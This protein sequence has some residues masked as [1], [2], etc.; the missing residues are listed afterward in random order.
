M[1]TSNL[2]DDE[3][4]IV[5]IFLDDITKV[6][7]LSATLGTVL[8]LELQ[9]KAKNKPVELY[10]GN[11]LEKAYNLVYSHSLTENFMLMRL[12]NLS[13]NLNFYFVDVHGLD[14]SNVL[15]YITNNNIQH[16]INSLDLSGT[17]CFAGAIDQIADLH[18][19][20]FE[21]IIALNLEGSGGTLPYCFQILLNI[22]EVRLEDYDIDYRMLLP[23]YF[24]N[25]KVLELVECKVA[26]FPRYLTNLKM[27]RCVFKDEP[28]FPWTISELFIE[29]TEGAE[30]VSKIVELGCQPESN[31]KRL[32][33]YN[34]EH[35]EELIAY[36]FALPNLK[37]LEMN[38]PRNYKLFSKTTIPEVVFTRT[39]W[40]GRKKRFI[41]KRSSRKSNGWCLTSKIKAR[42]AC[43]VSNS[44]KLLKSLLVNHLFID[45][46]HEARDMRLFIATDDRSVIRY[47]M[48]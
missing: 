41:F 8:N 39:F 20:Y 18:E 37:Y 5:F 44:V 1:Y 7:M 25:I 28:I 34:A 46:V 47:A 40:N 26:L 22:T 19:T 10:F 42:F 43:L 38:V 17:E 31:L 3:L 30:Y 48:Q 4:A 2:T 21:K 9:R 16:K 35:F 33:Y 11:T 14:I 15:S 24:S 45:S 13:F 6:N 32:T 23:F 36:F 27:V 12:M 29:D